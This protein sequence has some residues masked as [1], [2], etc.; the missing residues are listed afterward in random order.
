MLSASNDMELGSIIPTEGLTRV[1]SLC[2]IATNTFSSELAED[3][4]AVFVSGSTRDSLEC[5]KDD[6]GKEGACVDS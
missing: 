3:S 2:E 4:R 1:P 6:G 5:V